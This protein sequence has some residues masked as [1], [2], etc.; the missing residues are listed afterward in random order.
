MASMRAFV[1]TVA[2]LF[3][4]DRLVPAAVQRGF[5]WD[6]ADARALLDGIDR[7]FS[8]VHVEESPLEAEAAGEHENEARC[9]ETPLEPAVTGPAGSEPAG[10]LPAPVSAATG[11]PSNLAATEASVLDPAFLASPPAGPTRAGLGVYFLGSMVVMRASDG[12]LEIYDGLQRTTTLTVLL[13]V[14]RDLEG[15]PDTRQRFDACVRDEA[16]GG[17]LRLH[18]KDETLWR[19]VQ[20]PRGARTVRRITANRD[21]GRRLQRIERL[22]VE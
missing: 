11:E 2:R 17:R 4:A 13:A 16:E 10:S 7:T 14:L 20:M 22:F 3:E 8:E 5:E 1:W 9:E 21:V 15:D 6:E 19:D 12:T 18:G